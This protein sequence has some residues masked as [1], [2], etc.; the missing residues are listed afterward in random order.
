MTNYVDQRV[1]KT[2][3]ETIHWIKWKNKIR[4]PNLLM[5]FIDNRKPDPG[6]M[7]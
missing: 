2:A 7:V 4:Y 1:Y 5:N 6:L 3:L